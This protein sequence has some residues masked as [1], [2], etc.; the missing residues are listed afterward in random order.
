MILTSL[1][2]FIL[3]LSVGSF[4]NVVYFRLPRKKHFFLSRSYCPSCGK[5]L[6]GFE[7]IPLLSFIIQRGRCRTCQ[8]PISF[9]YPLVEGTT[10]LLFLFAYLG[11]DNLLSYALSDLLMFFLILAIVAVLFLI[12]LY[13]A[14]HMIIPDEFIVI[15]LLLSLTNSLIVIVTNSSQTTLYQ[16][17]FLPIV[18][19]FLVSIFFFSVILIT[20]G[21]GMGFGDVKLGFWLGILV[22][23]PNIFLL[24]F[25]AFL[26]GALVSLFLIF[27][28]QKKL[29]DS[30][31]F[32]PF[33]VFGTY[34]S[35]FWG[36]EIISFYLSLH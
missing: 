11:R 17:I 6:K 29:K 12:L 31:A 32:G 5:E 28:S 9:I 2:V 27:R 1:F 3:G 20:R 26:S 34:L 18:T 35:L 10:G 8:K 33:L 15:G 21:R 23:Y 14:K 19:G 30:I 24:L 13:D 25:L 36:N 4:L 7:L 22:P 16:T